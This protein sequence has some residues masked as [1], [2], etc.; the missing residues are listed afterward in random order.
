MSTAETTYDEDYKLVCQV[1]NRLR[2][3]CECPEDDLD[4][5]QDATTQFAIDQFQD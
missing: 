5:D 4:D 2:I 1:C 3:D